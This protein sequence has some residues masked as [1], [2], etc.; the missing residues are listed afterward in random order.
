LTGKVA[1][2]NL[3]LLEVGTVNSRGA[4]NLD[5]YAGKDPRDIPAYSLRE[6]A[7]YLNLP[8]ATL[9]SWVMG[10]HYHVGSRLRFFEPLIRVP[11]AE[12]PLLS[13]INLTEAYVLGA[14]RRQHSIPLQQVRAALRYLE[15]QFKSR[16]P[17]ADHQ[18][19]TDGWSL[20]VQKLDQ[21]INL[22]QE[23]QFEMHELLLQYLR[24]IDRDPSGAVARLY[25]LTRRGDLDQPRTVVVDPRIA[26]GKPVLARRAIPTAV[27]AERYKGGDS[28]DVLARDYDCERPEIEEAIRCELQVEAA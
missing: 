19:E 25:L 23:G 28:T 18:F 7:H 3:L 1:Y 15:E 16:H 8:K 12:S 5:V 27:I 24:R 22:T 14:I 11:E 20:F 17:L 10:Q 6:A 21:L 4:K 9:R 26:F 2:G 13:F